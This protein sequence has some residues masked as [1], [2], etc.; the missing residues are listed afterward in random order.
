M[1]RTLVL[2]ACLIPVLLS[3]IYGRPLPIDFNTGIVALKTNLESA[4]RD[5]SLNRLESA[6]LY[7]TARLRLSALQ[8]LLLKDRNNKD[9]PFL[10]GS[11]SLLVE[12]ARLQLRE[13][14]LAGH[15]AN[16][17]S[18]LDSALTDLNAV[19][20]HII[21]M[22]KGRAASL[23]SDLEATR[24][25]AKQI[26]LEAQQKM[27]QLQE[28]SQQKIKQMREEAQRR[29]GELQGE[30]IKVRRDARGTIISMSDILFG[31][32]Q[33]DVKGPLMTSLAKIA[34]ILTVYK[35]FN[36]TVEGHTDNQGPA[37][38]N[39]KLSDRRAQNVRTY[40]SSQGIDSTRM[41]AVGYGLTRPVAENT[42]REGQQKNRRV[43]LVIHDPVSR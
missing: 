43:D 21:G 3:E 34:G 22:E 20:E 38:Y 8:D 15:A 25:K 37:E 5:Y 40:L 39:Q 12:A 29:F 28:E 7:V 26:E 27:K 10:F 42:T 36:I 9:L 1:I 23:K 6:D 24:E 4:Y 11:C 19:H 32:N 41:A 17:Q 33:A 13:R 16:L 14:H 2:S 30:L 31:I 18:S 35:D